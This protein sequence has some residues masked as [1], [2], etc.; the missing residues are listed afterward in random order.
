MVG[1]DD[2]GRTTGGQ[3]LDDV[4]I[5]RPLDQVGC[6]GDLG[7]C[8]AAKDVNK[9]MA[10]ALPLFFRILDTVEPIKEVFGVVDNDEASPHVLSERPLYVFAFMFS[11]ESVVDENACDLIA[12]GPVHQGR[13]HRRIHAARE[14][15]NNGG[16][17]DRL[18]DRLDRFVDEGARCPGRTASADSQEEV[19]DDLFAANGVRRLWVKLDRIDWAAVMLA[20]GD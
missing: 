20:C 19:R 18:P 13:G 16:V 5:Q 15:A 2:P 7:T 6:P 3:R 11:E 9:G 4:G 14:P 17:P 12:N 1:F 10:D 8:D